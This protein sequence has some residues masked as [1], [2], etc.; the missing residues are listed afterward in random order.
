MTMVTCTDRFGADINV[1]DWIIYTPMASEG[2]QPAKMLQHGQ[3][4]SISKMGPTVF[5]NIKDVD[6]IFT[7]P[8]RCFKFSDEEMTMRKLETGL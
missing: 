8:D 5:I 1:G 7:L 6:G 2:T 4:G 3:I